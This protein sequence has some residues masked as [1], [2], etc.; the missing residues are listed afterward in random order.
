MT[1]NEKPL[2]NVGMLFEE[3]YNELLPKFTALLPGQGRRRRTPRAKK[4]YRLARRA[5]RSYFFHGQPRE[6]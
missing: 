5:R 2:P 4:R 6:F 1:T 3:P